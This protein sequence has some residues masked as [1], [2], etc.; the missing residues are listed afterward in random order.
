MEVDIKNSD[1]SLSLPPRPLCLTFSPSFVCAQVMH[2]Y[3]YYTSTPPV[4]AAAAV[5]RQRTTAGG[6]DDIESAQGHMMTP[7]PTAY[8]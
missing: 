5:R 1:T 8:Y 2:I 4:A 7:H 6:V 3:E